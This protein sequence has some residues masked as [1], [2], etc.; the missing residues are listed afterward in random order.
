MHQMRVKKF[1]S[2]LL[3]MSGYCSILQ[4]IEAVESQEQIAFWLQEQELSLT[5]VADYR[6][7]TELL[8][9]RG[10]NL[11]ASA[12]YHDFKDLQVNESI[13]GWKLLHEKSE[14]FARNQLK[15]SRPKI[16]KLLKESKVSNACQGA[17]LQTLNSIERLDS[18]A[19]RSKCKTSVPSS[20]L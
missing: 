4:R 17:S 7:L 5:S 15:M 20:E 12:D 8:Q 2:M 16:M 1:A 19:V 10:P 11:R 18:W 3:V 13:V 9:R 14:L 6:K